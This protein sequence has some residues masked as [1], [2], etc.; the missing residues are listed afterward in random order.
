MN[1]FRHDVAHIQ[2]M[3]IYD[4]INVSLRLAQ[5]FFAKHNGLNTTY[6]CTGT[7]LIRP[8]YGTNSGIFEPPHDKTNKM[9]VRPAKA[10]ISLGIRPVLSVFAVRSVVAEDPNFLHADSE[11]SDQTGRR[12]IW[13]FAGRTGI[14]LVL[15]SGGLFRI[16][17]DTDGRG[18]NKRIGEVSSNASSAFIFKDFELS[19]IANCVYV[20]SKMIFLCTKI[21]WTPREEL[22]PSLFRLG[23][24]TLPSGLSKC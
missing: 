15:T 10:L 1:R 19:C 6:N 5:G 17:T 18:V 20:Q 14:L 11:D 12:L 9:T 2:K 16:V 8:H 4:A 13:V 3:L 7:H 23:F 21:C 24:S 22:K